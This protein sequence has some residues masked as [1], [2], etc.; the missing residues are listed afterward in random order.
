M[1]HVGRRGEFLLFLAL[2]DVVVGFSLARPA[3][4]AQRT[5]SVHLLSEV[6]PLSWWA[7]LW[8]FV[9]VVCLWGAFRRG[10]RFAYACAAG[11]KVLWGGLFLFGWLAGEVVRGW[12]A[13]V[14]WL[15]FAV[16]VAR[17]ASWPEP[18]A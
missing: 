5:P 10:D 17:I 1:T 4:Q 2:L 6:A 15:V 9:A 13:A 12:A 11:L 14:I 7:G 18:S 8:L 16:F 3:P